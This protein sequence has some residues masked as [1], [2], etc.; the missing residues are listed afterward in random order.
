MDEHWSSTRPTGSVEAHEGMTSKVALVIKKSTREEN[1]WCRQGIYDSIA[2]YKRK[3]ASELD[4]L[5]ASSNAQPTGEDLGMNFF[6]ALD[7]SQY[8]EF[9]QK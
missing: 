6:P 8:A 1:S 7:N 9:T 5:K 2:D 4:A 3:F